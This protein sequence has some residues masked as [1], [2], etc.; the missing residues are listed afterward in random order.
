M[1]KRDLLDRPLLEFQPGVNSVVSWLSA[2][3]GVD[4]ENM[5]IGTGRW[6]RAWVATD[7]AR[8]T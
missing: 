7:A 1:R 5:G 3:V 4:G 2:E 6:N 8:R